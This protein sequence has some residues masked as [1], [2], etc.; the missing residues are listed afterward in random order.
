[1]AMRPSPKPH[2]FAS[3]P[4]D[5]VPGQ[6]S[7][8]AWLQAQREDPRGRYLPFRVLEAAVSPNDPQRLGWL[9]RRDAEAWSAL[10]DAI[11]LGVLDGVSHFAISIEASDDA[12]GLEFREARGL[13][14]EL[15][16]PEAGILAQARSMLQWHWTHR[17]CSEC[18][19]ATV[20]IEGGARR[21][22]SGCGVRSYPQISPSMIVLVE[23]NDR[24]LLARRPRGPLNRF[25]CLAGYVEPGESIEDS[26]AREVFEESG[27]RIANV[28]YHSSQPWPFPATLMIGCIAEAASDEI[29][30]DGVEIAEARWF[31]RDEVR[32]AIAG[33][34]PELLVP[35][36]I[37]IAN[38]LIRAWVED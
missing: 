25:S 27:V 19:T 28:R 21:Q 2:V 15:A 24:C 29:A 37:A 12:L 5:R 1:M 11:F 4:L 6:R 33:E 31:S 14:T 9:V 23:R 35:D 38:H 26:V 30:V 3:N 36:G 13:A 18:G 32:R 8:E 16:L 22:C 10:G 7:D 17:F 20:S 34:N